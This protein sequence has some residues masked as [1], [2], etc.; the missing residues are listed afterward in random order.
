MKKIPII[1]LLILFFNCSE[2]PKELFASKKDYTEFKKQYLLE[3]SCVKNVEKKHEIHISP[4]KANIR[5]QPDINLNLT[6][7]EI[8]KTL[9]IRNIKDNIIGQ[10]EKGVYT[11]VFIGLCDGPDAER[12]WY[13]IQIKKEYVIINKDYETEIKMPFIRGWISSKVISEAENSPDYRVRIKQDQENEKRLTEYEA[14]HAEI[15]GTKEEK[16]DYIVKKYKEILIGENSTNIE[17]EKIGVLYDNLKQVYSKTLIPEE[18]IDQTLSSFI[19]NYE[20]KSYKHRLPDIVYT[21]D[22]QIKEGLESKFLSVNRESEK[23]YYLSLLKTPLNNYIRK[24]ISIKRLYSLGKGHLFNNISLV[25]YEIKLKYYVDGLIK[26]YEH[27]IKIP[28]YEEKL[29]KLYTLLNRKDIDPLYSLSAGGSSIID[30]ELIKLYEEIIIDKDVCE[31]WN[32]HDVSHFK[33]WIDSFWI[34]R[35]NEQ[36]MK[37]VYKILLNIRKHYNVRRV[38]DTD[39]STYL[40]STLHSEENLL[41]LQN[42]EKVV[43]LEKIDDW[44]KV[45]YTDKVGYLHKSKIIKDIK[46][47]DNEEINYWEKAIIN[48]PDGYTNIRND[49]ND[50]ILKINEGEEFLVDTEQTKNNVWLRVNYNGSEGWV[51]KSR[52]KVVN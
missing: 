29:E 37:T 9:Q 18:D 1:I 8:S 25:E 33:L 7:S 27:I 26:S 42:N 21:L 15:E 22:S 28:L 24:P 43:I 47:N 11:V 46:I 3:S 16:H 40:K 50:I 48:D 19:F 35:Y 23:K 41:E 13:Y 10:I 39:G 20:L 49:N 52:I 12:D 31:E 36:N 4:N 30:E 45:S 32:S 44:Y 51:H 17:S 6:D 38:Y 5:F 14:R 2:K 34:R